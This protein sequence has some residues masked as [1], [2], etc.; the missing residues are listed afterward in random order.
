MLKV[1][2]Q[3][4]TEEMKA[5]LIERIATQ[6]EKRRLNVPAIMFLEM[7]KPLANLVGHAA[8]A[9]SPFMMPFLGFKTVDEYSQ[10]FSERDNVEQLIRRLESGPVESNSDG[11]KTT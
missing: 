2:E 9:F 11:D 10:F 4:L 3:P 1:W 8:I 5:A 7:H 6:I